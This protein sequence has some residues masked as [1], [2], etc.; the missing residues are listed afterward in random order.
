MVSHG[1]I[2][3][4]NQKR[5]M[6]CCEWSIYR[7]VATCQQVATSLSVSSNLSISSS[8]NKSVNHACYNLSFADLLKLVETTC[9]RPVDNKF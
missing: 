8:C 3:L 6:T 2:R 4:H 9:S 7:F 5:H 1:C